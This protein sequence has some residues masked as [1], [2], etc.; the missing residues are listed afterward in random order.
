MSELHNTASATKIREM[1]LATTSALVLAAYA[2]ISQT[3][4]ADDKG[5]PTVWIEGGWHFE[6][7]TGEAEAFVP[8]LDAYAGT[9]GLPSLPAIENELGRTYGAE[10]SISFQP[11]TSDWILTVSARYGRSQTTRRV[12][13][14]KTIVG[15]PMMKIIFQSG[16]FTN[17]LVTPTL[18]AYAVNY[19]S[20]G[21]AH[22]IADFQVGK[23]IG[24]GLFGHGTDTII[25]FGARYAQMNAKSKAHSYDHP[26]AT[27]VQG[28]FGSEFC[29]QILRQNC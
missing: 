11:T 26:D 27:F 1:L 21:E 4:Q 8:P 16:H 3:A 24:I 23:D 17:L 12:Q 25:S 7:V 9:T 29:S 19:S 13:V 10:G 6:S 20:N 28:D 18:D 5:R 22:A 2:F 14:L 15:P